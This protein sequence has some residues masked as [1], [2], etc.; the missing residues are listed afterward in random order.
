M[1]GEIEATKAISK[2]THTS[3]ASIARICTRGKVF[4]WK[5][6]YHHVCR[7]GACSRGIETSLN[8]FM[9]YMYML[10]P[11]CVRIAHIYLSPF[12]YYV[13]LYH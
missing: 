7:S 6:S 4:C 11:L 8:N 5:G 9:K 10:V 13:I 3:I 1:H 2:S 12:L